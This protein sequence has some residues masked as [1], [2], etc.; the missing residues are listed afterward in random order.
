MLAQADGGQA[1]MLFSW[2]LPS[3]LALASLNI[4]AASRIVGLLEKAGVTERLLSPIP[5][6]HDSQGVPSSASLG[7]DLSALLEGDSFCALFNSPTSAAAAPL[8]PR[9]ARLNQSSDSSSS[10]PEMLWATWVISG[11][12][13]HSSSQTRNRAI[14][15]LPDLLQANRLI[16][17]RALP[18]VLYAL[19]A[20]TEPDLRTRLLGCLPAFGRHQLGSQMVQAIIR[21]LHTLPPT[22]D[23]RLMA[24]MASMSIRLATSLFS[25]NTRTLPRLSSML[26]EE[27]QGLSDEIDEVRLTRA[28][29]MLEVIMEDPE[30]GADYVAS[31]QRYLKDQVP[32]IVSLAID[33]ITYLCTADCL[34]FMAAVR[35]LG[36]KGRVGHLGHPLVMASLADLYGAATDIFDLSPEVEE[37]KEPNAMDKQEEEEPRP[38]L[39]E[40]T[41]RTVVDNLWALTNHEDGGVRGRAFAGLAGFVPVLLASEDLQA[42]QALRERLLQSLLTEE[43]EHA[44]EGLLEAVRVV[45]TTESEDSATWSAAMKSGLT[46]IAGTAAKPSRKA[47]KNMPTREEMARLYG[48]A[49]SAGL[50]SALMLASKGEDAKSLMEALMDG[51]SDEDSGGRCYLQRLVSPVGFHRLVPELLK[52]L[53]EEDVAKGKDE[54]EASLSAVEAVEA[55][56]KQEMARERGDGV[57]A[58]C[59][60]ALAALASSLPQ[61][62]FHK[63]DEYLTPLLEILETAAVSIAVDVP[64]LLVSI[65]LIGRCL[66]P[67]YSTRVHTILASIMASRDALSART[68]ADWCLWGVNLSLGLLT[69][70]VGQQYSPDADA[71]TLLREA[72]VALIGSMQERTHSR[73]LAKTGCPG[74]HLLVVSTV[75]LCLRLGLVQSGDVFEVFRDLSTLLDSSQPPEAAIVGLANLVVGVQGLIA[76][77]TGYVEDLR[78]RLL[79]ILADRNTDHGRRVATMGAMFTLIANG[80]PFF[81]L[82]SPS[83]GAGMS[84]DKTLSAAIGSFVD[85]LRQTMDGP[86]QRCRNAASR[87]LGLLVALRQDDQQVCPPF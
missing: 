1:S 72:T 47:L 23:K 67:S 24:V 5:S 82:L 31:L 43:D 54:F 15:L 10:S 3:T 58:P 51:L 77:P 69:D 49:K 11:H 84:Q 85:R 17:L 25:I 86:S 27:S 87:V 45:L 16:G 19:Q 68:D 37:E 29:A 12:L 59:Y 62:L 32:S 13:F 61:Q 7:D 60:L 35:I 79:A 74:S 30:A 42:G 55:I 65:S 6:T 14:A 56:V 73:A 20:W 34:D 78:G 83:V 4:Q 81:S 70:W 21:R 64:A 38:R 28:Q 44:K 53:R 57:T 66:G 33:G 50:A 18:S 80:G 48:Q 2:V 63:A 52:A 46:T 71:M 41:L 76:L 22:A 75:P 40:K 8:G 26:V 39:P 9:I 36:K